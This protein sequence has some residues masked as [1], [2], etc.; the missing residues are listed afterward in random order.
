[1]T[2]ST[3]VLLCTIAAVT[4][5][6]ASKKRTVCSIK[7]EI[8]PAKAIRQV[9]LIRNGDT[10]PAS[11]TGTRLNVDVKPGVYGVWIDAIAPYQDHLTADIDLFDNNSMELGNIELLQ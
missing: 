5:L 1:M 6:E 11:L 8:H 3:W 7:G 10:I 4:T 2:K 9:W